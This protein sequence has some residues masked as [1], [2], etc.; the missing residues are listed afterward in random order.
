[1]IFMRVKRFEVDS[2]VFHGFHDKGITRV[3]KLSTVVVN[4]FVLKSYHMQPD[5]SVVINYNIHNEI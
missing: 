3:L 5:I 2:M 4:C 1:M